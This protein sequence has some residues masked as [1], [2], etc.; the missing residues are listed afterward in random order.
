METTKNFEI[1]TNKIAI[2]LLVKERMGYSGYLN[3]VLLKTPRGIRKERLITNMICD[4][5]DTYIYTDNYKFK[6][7]TID[8]RKY[9]TIEY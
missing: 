5:V 8:I 2:N 9:I 3:N 1:E 4:G 7:K 6:V